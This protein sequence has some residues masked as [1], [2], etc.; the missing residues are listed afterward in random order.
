MDAVHIFTCQQHMLHISQIEV[1]TCEVHMTLQDSELSHHQWE[2]LSTAVY[3]DYSVV[4]LKWVR[5]LAGFSLTTPN[6]FP[7]IRILWLIWSIWHQK[8]HIDCD[9]SPFFRVKI[10][11]ASPLFFLMECIYNQ[12]CFSNVRIINCKV[13]Q[14]ISYTSDNTE[15]K[16]VN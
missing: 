12:I 14:Q 9:E 7:W 3:Y 8:F 6:H 13:L 11:Y 15:T 1:C 10:I 4:F 2:P 5:V 16:N